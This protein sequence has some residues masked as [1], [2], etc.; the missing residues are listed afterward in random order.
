MKKKLILW[1]LIFIPV[2]I[3]SMAALYC[4]Y[5]YDIGYFDRKKLIGKKFDLSNL[6]DLKG[7]KTGLKLK[8]DYTI[9]DFW[10]KGCTPCLEEMKQF[11]GLISGIEEQLTIVSI[12]V[13][14]VNI[15]EPLFSENSAIPFLKKKVNNWDHYALTDTTIVQKDTTTRVIDG[16]KIY[17][18]SIATTRSGSEFIFNEYGIESFPTYL[19]LDK[20]GIVI[21][22]PY[23][24]TDYIRKNFHNQR[25][26]NRFWTSIGLDRIIVLTIASFVIHSILYWLIVLIVSIVRKLK[27]KSTVANKSYM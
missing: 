25:I 27:K 4:W 21:D 19:V 14:H 9:V 22:C 26:V 18:S 7:N 15:W 20:A 3:V 24:G 2:L 17:G 13:D 6:I 8:T 1:I 5:Q 16:I 12:S 11:E 23:K 10:F